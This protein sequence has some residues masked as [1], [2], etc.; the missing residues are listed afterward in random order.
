MYWIRVTHRWIGLSCLL[1]IAVLGFSGIILD[2][3]EWRWAQQWSV[4]DR[5]ASKHQLTEVVHG[6]IIRFFH[7]NPVD[8]QN[9]IG[10]GT[11]GLWRTSDSGEHWNAVLFEGGRGVPMVQAILPSLS[12]PWEVLWLGTD[13][14]LWLVSGRDG[15]AS[16]VALPG[17]HVTA[18]D[19]DAQPGHLVGI[20]E[21]TKIFTVDPTTPDTVT[22]VHPSSVPIPGLPEEIGLARF[23]MDLHFGKGFTPG[24]TSMWINDYAGMVM[25][26][27]AITGFLYW[28]FP[29]RW[30]NRANRQ[31]VSKEVRQ[32]S[33][34]WIYNL[35]S[36]VLG[37]LAVVPIIYLS[38]TGIYMDHARFF[39]RLDDGITF[40]RSVMPG[41]FQLTDLTW[42]L[43]SLAAS[44][45]DIGHYSVMTRMGLIRTADGGNTWAFDDTTPV[46]AHT[47]NVIPSHVHSEGYEYVGV[48]GGP[49]Y[50]RAD[51][52]N[53]WEGI[54]AL[55]MMIMDGSLAGDTWFFKGSNGFS[56]W[57]P[58]G[59]AVRLDIKNPPLTG[60]PFNRFMADVHN[61]MVFHERFKLI[62]DM[63]CLFAI[64]LCI[65]GVIQWWRKKW[66]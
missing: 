15:T 21:K 62:N 50:R 54:P 31:K 17:H 36:P 16:Q 25:I 28:L 39:I 23:M 13:D 65:T 47:Y 51:N 3:P 49:N 32:K 57:Q 30:M 41:A 45:T 20:V 22:W 8:H 33:L 52:S 1:W 40:G 43:H 66:A 5:F 2:H 14:G 58:G 38:I 61:G 18:L 11:R 48:Y 6:N 12:D 60:V 26:T 27:L 24:R 9:I 34:K 53:A 37:L 42:E 44:P 10:G 55:R 56:S 59:D 64:Y 29:R 46:S 63:V 19:H 4:T 35:H 7:V